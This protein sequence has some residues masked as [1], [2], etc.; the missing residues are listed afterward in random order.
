MSIQKKIYIPLIGV[1]VL[2]F[3]S[4]GINYF[5][6]I[7]E[8]KENVYA[9]ESQNLR[10][11][12]AG[13]L[14]VIKDMGIAN[15]LGLAKNRAV[16][17]SL[18]DGN[19]QT[20]AIG[21]EQLLEE[22]TNSTSM[23]SPKVHIHTADVKSFLRHWSPKKFDDDLSGFRHTILEVK[24]TK[25]P[26]VAVELG[27]SGL[28]IRGI[29]PIIVS[30]NYIGSVEFMQG[31]NDIVENANKSK[32]VFTIL[33]KKEL[34]K[35]ATL[36]GDK[37]KLGDFVIASDDKGLNP[38]FIQD[39]TSTDITQT[40]RSFTGENY[41]FVSE[42]IKDFSGTVVAYAITGESLLH[43]LKVLEDSRKVII[44][45]M[46]LMVISCIVIFIVLSIVFYKGVLAPIKNLKD[47]AQQLASSDADLS[48]RVNI[49]TKDELE[50][51]AKGFN[52]FIEKVEQIALR[53]QE[54][55][56]RA[57]EGQK[58]L[59]NASKKEH[60]KAKLTDAMAVGFKRD[61][62]DLQKSFL[63][64][65]EI[66]NRVNSLNETNTTVSIQVQDNIKEIV[67]TIE[68]IVHLINDSKES[69]EQLNR[70][71]DDISQVISLIKDIS[72]Q[73]NLLALNAAIEA[74]RAGE[75]GRGFAVVADEVRK[76]AERT[77]KATGEI[78]VS[79]NVLKQNTSSM[80]DNAQKS[81]ESA[82]HSSEKLFTFQG[83]LQTLI[84]NTQ[85][86][87]KDNETI[88]YV[89]IADLAKIDHVIFK[90]NGYV[91]LL[92]E[93]ITQEFADHHHCRFGRW[94]ESDETQQDFNN[95]KSYSSIVEPHK[96]VHQKINFVV[97]LLKNKQLDE[98]RDIVLEN[99]K[100]VESNSQKLFASLDQMIEEKKA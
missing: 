94:Y 98:K 100:D 82:A 3:L 30:D 31:F 35:T 21:I 91:T 41:L 90:V 47:I 96:N 63:E 12:Y 93:K 51:V 67:N 32:K 23:K 25:K 65:I 1:F 53:A 11:F 89:L 28:E 20:A 26:L 50:E 13:E 58:S 19:R 16:I 66:I 54:E 75:H 27:R 69:S 81:E 46:L 52:A 97:G 74:A 56:Y 85:H 77:Q 48:K 36:L 86:I 44:N 42:E 71:V 95:S 9:K 15:A 64:N 29:S 60:F 7:K 2:L 78:E 92:D 49:N 99:M 45:Q 38:K 62:A 24:K 5:S 22:Y 61:T 6:S 40:S 8:I 72:D 55:T 87:K 68:G 10:N 18:L 33:M 88:S 84:Q 83:T 14:K 4:L 80:L 73:T 34:L 79:I 76:L 43:V 37:Q 17:E 70:S 57:Q 59:E 39:L